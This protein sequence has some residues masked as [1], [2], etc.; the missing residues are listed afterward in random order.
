MRMTTTSWRVKRLSHLAL[1]TALALIFSYLESLVPLP[2]M[3]PGFKL[4]LCN[5]VVL[6]CAYRLSLWDAAILSLV[7]VLVTALLFGNVTGFLFSLFGAIFAFLAIVFA[8]TLLLKQLSFVGVSVLSAAAF[9]FGQILAASLLYASV[10]VFSYLPLLLV[11]SAVFG[12][13]VGL[14]LNLIFD[15]LGKGIKE[16]VW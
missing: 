13:A 9:N 3:L 12:G 5:V 15:R 16:G 1:L 10:S 11:A 14:L 6:F 8:K 7:R 2:M 4:G